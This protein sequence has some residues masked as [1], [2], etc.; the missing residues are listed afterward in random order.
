VNEFICN[1]PNSQGVFG[2]ADHV[3]SGKI[4]MVEH[5]AGRGE[6]GCRFYFSAELPD[7]QGVCAGRGCNLRQVLV[8]YRV[9]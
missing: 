7:L 8:G 1:M 3:D 4:R 6:R 5:I 2:D 9:N